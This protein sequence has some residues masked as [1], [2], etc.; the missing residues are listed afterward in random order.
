M[1]IAKMMMMMMMMMI[2]L[3]LMLLLMLSRIVFFNTVR[4]SIQSKVRWPQLTMEGR[5]CSTT[6]FAQAVQHCLRV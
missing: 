5:L 3:L 4:R 1:L 6:S 2:M